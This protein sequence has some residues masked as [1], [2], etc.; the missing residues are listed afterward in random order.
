MSDLTFQPGETIVRQGEHG[1]DFY[2][3]AEGKVSVR[4]LKDGNPEQVNQLHPGDYFGEVALLDDRPRNATVVAMEP[5]RCY[6]LDKSQFQIIMD[7]AQ[8]F[9]TELRNALFARQ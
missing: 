7:S 1:D 9:E 3:I 4:V 2:I 6:L 8:S 5:T